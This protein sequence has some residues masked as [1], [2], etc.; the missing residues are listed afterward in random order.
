MKVGFVP[1]AQEH[2]IS[3]HG[4]LQKSHVREFWDD[5]DRTLANVERHYFQERDVTA[6]MIVLDGRSVGYLQAYPVLPDADFAHWRVPAGETWGLDLFFGEPDV[7][8][9]GLAPDVL[10][11]FVTFC[12]GERPGL[13]RVLIDRRRAILA[14]STSTARSG[15]LFCEK[16]SRMESFW[17]CTPSTS[18]PRNGLRCYVERHDRGRQPNPAPYSLPASGRRRQRG[19]R[20]TRRRRQGDCERVLLACDTN[21]AIYT[22]S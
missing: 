3:L 9:H 10:R 13:R 22:R 4:W 16:S 11:A 18:Y 17:P 14:P 21:M 1:L 7:L 15:F 2:L 19:P 8:G 20:L 5:G 6:F 12:R